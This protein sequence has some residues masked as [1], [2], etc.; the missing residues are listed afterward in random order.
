MTDRMR[1]CR[2]RFTLKIIKINYFSRNV[3]LL[4]CSN[5]VCWQI[6]LLSVLFLETANTTLSNVL[7]FGLFEAG[8]KARQDILVM[9]Q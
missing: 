3:D 4:H 2:I 9:Q 8:I 1:Y 6:A 5:F 7:K